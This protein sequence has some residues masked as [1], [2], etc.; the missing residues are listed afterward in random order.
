M[1]VMVLVLVMMMMLRQQVKIKTVELRDELMARKQ[2][3]EEQEK[4]ISDLQ[5]ASAKIKTLRGIIPIC[6][7]CKKI[8]DDEGYWN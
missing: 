6:A 2:A 1:F 7:K 8:R 4:L 3:E 5:A